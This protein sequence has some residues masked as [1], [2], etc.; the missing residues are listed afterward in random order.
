MNNQEIPSKRGQICKLADPL[1]DDNPNEHYLI[2]EDLDNFAD[3]SMIFVISLIDLQKNSADP[4]ATPLKSV[5]KKD[6]TVVATDLQS[7][8]ASQN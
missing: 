5:M 8:V 1:P 2:I 4:S 7:F 6:L 3:N